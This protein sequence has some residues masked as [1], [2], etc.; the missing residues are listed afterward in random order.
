MSSSNEG[1][2]GDYILPEASQSSSRA[3]L[4]PPVTNSVSES[5]RH[6][7]INNFNE[8]HPPESPDTKF[9]R[10]RLGHLL[11]GIRTGEI[12]PNNRIARGSRNGTLDYDDDVGGGPGRPKKFQRRE[13]RVV[14]E[15]RGKPFGL[16]DS[17]HNEAVFTLCRTWM[18]GREDDHLKEDEPEVHYPAPDDDSLDLLATKEIRALPGPDE[19]KPLMSPVPPPLV[20]SIQTEVDINSADS[21]LNQHMQHWKAVKKHW[22]DYSKIRDDRYTKSI[23]LLETVYGIAQQNVL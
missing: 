1:S 9:A 6:E 8:K 17:G 18:R 20:N 21:I 10:N 16:R 5:L 3:Q 7:Q 4:T 15:L 22:H 2:L 23:Q 11:T 14:F 13:R 12:Q 19:S